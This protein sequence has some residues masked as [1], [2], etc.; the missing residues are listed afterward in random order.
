MTEA[1]RIE[2][3]TD[4]SSITDAILLLEHECRE[5]ERAHLASD[6]HDYPMQNIVAALMF[7]EMEGCAD[8]VDVRTQMHSRCEFQLRAAARSLRRM[9]AG[10]APLEP[11]GESLDSH[12]TAVAQTIQ[13][14]YDVPVDMQVAP[15][16]PVTPIVARNA[17]R[18]VCELLRNAGK[19]ARATQLGVNVTERDH[20]LVICVS[21]DGVGLPSPVCSTNTAPNVAGTGLRLT[22]N[23]ILEL[24]GSYQITSAPGCGTI[25]CIELPTGAGEEQQNA[26]NATDSPRYATSTA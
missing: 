9:I 24:G 26:P 6:L 13:N 17:I 4:L 22:L 18:V 15:D 1:A 14:D 21:D 19:H 10:L 11:L 25:V 8:E 2:R 7:L 23:R 3:S 20:N 5:Q 16:L 12:L